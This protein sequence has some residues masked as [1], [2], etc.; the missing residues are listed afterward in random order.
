[1]NNP[2]MKKFDLKNQ[3]CV[4]SG[5]AGLLGPKHAEAILNGNGKVVLLDINENALKKA[6]AKLN[7]SYPGKIWGYKIDI[8][9]ENEIKKIIKKITAGIGPISILIN[10]TAN[11]PHIKKGKTKLNRLENF[12]IKEWNQDITVGLTGAFL[13]SKLIGTQM[14]KNK[15]GVILNISSDLGII[16]P[17]QRLY[18]KTGVSES[19]Q[20]VKPITYSVVKHGIIGLTKYLATYWPNKNIRVNSVSFGG[21]YNN[22]PKKFVKK[23]SELIPLGRMANADEYEGIILFL[24]SD[25]SSYMT[26]ANVVIDGGRTIW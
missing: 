10:N 23:I 18:K 11:N 6:I 15:K 22:Q 17:D 4:I 2:T 8:T 13:L 26:G 9:E 7:K 19:R 20:P 1:M 25:A 5:G 3:L 21:V 12:P 24:C 16:A 14:A